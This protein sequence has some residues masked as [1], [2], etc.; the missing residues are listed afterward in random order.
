MKL[1]LRRNA[2]IGLALLVVALI[3]LR[4]ALPGLVRDFVNKKLATLDGY[5]G[6]VEDVDIAL[7]RG[8]YAINDVKIQKLKED[9]PVPYFEAPKVEFSVE[10]KELFHGALVSEIDV[11]RGKLNFVKEPQKKTDEPQTT[12]DW[13]RV[14]EELFPF[15]INRFTIHNGE[16]WYHDF[17]STPKVDIAITNMFAVATNLTNARDT[18]QDLPASIRLEG[19]S[20]GGGQ[21]QA[22]MKLNPLAYEPTFDMNLKLTNV[23]LTALNDFFEAYGKVDIDGGTLHLYGEMAAAEGSFK[24]YVKPL[25]R[26][27][28]IL[29][30]KKDNENPLKLAWETI[31]TGV[32]HLFSNQ[33]KD[34]F[35]TVVPFSGRFDDPQVG[36]WETIRAILKNAFV[37]A[38]RPGLDQN[39]ELK[40][41]S[42]TEKKK[43]NAKK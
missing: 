4:L 9:V 24:G 18:K 21:L 23:N 8:A 27:V 33:P 40:L 3:A 29:E 19:D 32:V 43:D 17:H 13:V 15:R 25:M 12:N 22:H 28:N 30:I 26:D 14:V 7:I 36:T 10:W 6:R 2:V 11:Y 31:V 16:V 41:G 34:Q 1:R 20:I 39:V 35:A 37:Q 42:K 5:R 38:L